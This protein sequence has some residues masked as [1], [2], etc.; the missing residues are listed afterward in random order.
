MPAPEGTHISRCFACISLGTQHSERFADTFKI[1]LMFELPNEMI[2]SDQGAKPAVVSKE[3]TLSLGK[4]SNLGQ[5]LNSWRGR[6]FTPEELKGFEVSNVVGAPCQVTI[7]HKQSQ[8][9]NTWADIAAITGIPKGMKAP[10]Q[11]HKSIKYE[12]EMLKNDVFESLPEWIQKKIAACEEWQSSSVKPP[13]APEPY[14]EPEE[15]E[16]NIPF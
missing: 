14:S 13:Q 7:Q 16:S 4:K 10:D 15:G 11:F 12:I 6:A 9:G 2:E 8:N 1:M 5:H 3:Y